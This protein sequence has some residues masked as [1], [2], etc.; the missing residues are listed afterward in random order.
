MVYHASSVV[1]GYHLGQKHLEDVWLNK[2]DLMIDLLQYLFV[3]I[4][5][6]LTPSALLS[7][8]QS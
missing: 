7:C 4:N 2:C 3:L 6:F 1:D 8:G 5:N